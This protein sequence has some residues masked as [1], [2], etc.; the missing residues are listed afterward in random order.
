MKHTVSRPRQAKR[1]LFAAATATCALALAF[2]PA[3][4]QGDNGLSPTSSQAP[5]SGVSVALEQCVTSV[6][7]SERSATFTGEMTAI[8]GTARM[9]MRIDVEE[10]GLED[11]E[12][13]PVVAAGPGTWRSSDPKVKVFKYLRQ[14]TNLSSPVAY[15]AL[16]RFRWFNAK[17]H[18]IRR[19]DRLTTRCVQPAA[20]PAPG[21]PEATAPSST[22]GAATGTSAG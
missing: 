21:T 3:G 2:V 12:F 4:A 22:A 15:R 17:G 19:V 18:V 9:A 20:P 13:H 6:Q 8:P 7:Q 16:V 11:P 10:R 5:A 14:V 1:A